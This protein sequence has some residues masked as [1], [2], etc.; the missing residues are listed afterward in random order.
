M[1][2]IVIMAGDVC[3]PAEWEIARELLQSN[4]YNVKIVER[5]PMTFEESFRSTILALECS[6]GAAIF[7]GHSWNKNNLNSEILNVGSIANI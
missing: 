6:E 4:G 1:K 7:V 2:N 3:D 5:K